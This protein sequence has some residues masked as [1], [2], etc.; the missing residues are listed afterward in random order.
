ML[1]CYFISTVS[2][3]NPEKY[4][5]GKLYMHCNKNIPSV[6]YDNNGHE[7]DNHY[8]YHDQ[9]ASNTSNTE[10]AVLTTPSFIYKQLTSI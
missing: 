7:D 1:L 2:S 3:Q 6:I 4:L 5:S 10:R 8:D 9:N